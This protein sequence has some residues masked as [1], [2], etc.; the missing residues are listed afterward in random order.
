M[1]S[2]KLKPIFIK[3]ENLIRIGPK[4]D[5]GYVIDKRIINKIDHLITC[6]LNDD[7]SFE[8]QFL[9]LNSKPLLNAYDHTVN[10]FFW[11]KKFSKDILDFFL[12]KKLSFYKI[13]NIFKYIEYLFFFRGPKKHHKLKVSKKNIDNKEISIDN[14]LK[15]KKNILLKIDI[16]GDEYKI[17]NNISKNS[18][19]ISCLIIE[20]HFIKQKLK[21]IYD[22]VDKTKNLKIAHIHAN[23]VAGVDKYGIPL[24]LEI[25]FINSN[26][27]ETDK[28]KNLQNYPIYKIDYPSV[29]RNKD[30]KLIFR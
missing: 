10:S 21:K 5:G 22:F 8:N 7:W 14:I 26:L 12:L 16:E 17:L 24:A 18:L 30:I 20:F 19:K 4:R 25:T 3:K 2:K 29:K 9:K 15:N 23:N 1:L 27:I 13:I 28:K 6:G 11:K